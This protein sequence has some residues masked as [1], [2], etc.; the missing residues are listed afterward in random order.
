MPSKPFQP[1]PFEIGSTIV[2]QHLYPDGRSVVRTGVIVG[3]APVLGAGHSRERWCVADQPLP[4]DLYGGGVVVAVA[5]GRGYS[6]AQRLHHIPA[7]EPFSDNH[8]SSPTGGIAVTNA[9][10][11]WQA[12][13]QHAA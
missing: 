9:R 7:G 2:W 13:Q 6:D 1:G 10:L 12:R 11:S 3:L 8:A 5:R 4:S